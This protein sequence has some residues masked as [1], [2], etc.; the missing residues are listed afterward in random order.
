MQCVRAVL[1]GHSRMW[2]ARVVGL[3]YVFVGGRWCVL[4]ALITRRALPIVAPIINHP[5]ERAHS[6]L[7]S[8]SHSFGQRFVC[9]C[10]LTVCKMYGNNRMLRLSIV[11]GFAI[12][13][14]VCLS[15]CPLAYLK[16]RVSKLQENFCTFCRWLWL[17]SRLL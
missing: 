15:V 14:S 6:A 7:Q 4:D 5:F 11:Q 2:R 17:G 8:A 1:T 13:V 9:F 10:C 3:R 16:N 12:S